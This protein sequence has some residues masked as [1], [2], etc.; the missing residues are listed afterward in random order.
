MHPFSRGKEFRKHGQVPSRALRQIESA[1]Q[2]R[3]DIWPRKGYVMN[4]KSP[5]TSDLLHRFNEAFLRH[6]PT[7][8][9]DLVD[10]DCVMESVEPAP[11]GTRYV[12]RDACLTFWQN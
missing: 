3:T 11:D 5:S 1:G 9:K 10:Q 12:G 4:E 8:L 2:R 6:D 7:L